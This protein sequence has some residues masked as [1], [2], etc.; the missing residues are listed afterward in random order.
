MDHNEWSGELRKEKVKK[1]FKKKKKWSLFVWGQSLLKSQNRS[2]TFYGLLLFVYILLCV[3]ALSWMLICRIKK[4]K[5]ILLMNKKMKRKHR[6]WNDFIYFLWIL[7]C[8]F[9]FF[10]L[11]CFILCKITRNNKTWRRG[12]GK[13]KRI[14]GRL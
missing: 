12:Q 3:I 8:L 14:K 11:T 5:K 7:F 2:K 10:Y 13:K 9:T 1:W 6:S 4:T